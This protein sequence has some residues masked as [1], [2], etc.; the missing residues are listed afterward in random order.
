MRNTLYQDTFMQP[1]CS[2]DTQFCIHTSAQLSHTF[3]RLRHSRDRITRIM[4]TH[5]LRTSQA[6][7]TPEVREGQQGRLRHAVPRNS[8]I[9][10]TLT[11]QKRSRNTSSASASHIAHIPPSPQQGNQTPSRNQRRTAPRL[12]AK[13]CVTLIKLVN[14]APPRSLRTF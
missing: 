12:E 2:T 9:T 10:T 11:I 13:S 3:F 5:D 14:T 4:Y 1:T 6:N 8:H 7:S